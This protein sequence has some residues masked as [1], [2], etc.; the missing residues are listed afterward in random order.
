MG[1]FTN[2]P[3]QKKGPKIFLTLTGRARQATLEKPVVE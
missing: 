1:R 3:N 2:F